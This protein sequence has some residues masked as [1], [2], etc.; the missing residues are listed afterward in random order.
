MSRSICGSCGDLQ[1]DDGCGCGAMVA[2]TYPLLTT[3][4]GSTCGACAALRADLA[5]AREREVVL[6][7]GSREQFAAIDRLTAERDA[8]RAE[9]ERLRSSLA[10]EWACAD[11]R[12]AELVQA[13]AEIERLRGL[14]REFVS[15]RRE[16]SHRSPMW[17][18]RYYA[19]EVA[20]LDEAKP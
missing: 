5:A 9:V 4:T 16:I 19:A 6:L 7:G 12:T 8:A 17:S 11:R 18:E 2:P 15:A 10:T 1:G 14:I 3:Y 13:E 20:L